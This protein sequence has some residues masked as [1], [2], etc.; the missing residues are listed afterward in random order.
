[1]KKRCGQFIIPGLITNIDNNSSGEMSAYILQN[2]TK[3]PCI[4]KS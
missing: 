1:M 2:P 3:C 4:N